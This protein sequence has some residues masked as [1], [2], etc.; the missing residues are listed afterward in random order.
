[1]VEENTDHCINWVHLTSFTWPHE[2]LTLK[3]FLE[4]NG[5]LV[6]ARDELTISI[7]PLLSNAMGGIKL[8]VSDEQFDM[9]SLLFSDFLK[10]M[11]ETPN[12]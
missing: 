7:D 6:Y 8:Y 4:A 2:Y 3:A 10:K 11:N 1:M 12:C 5:I 9:A